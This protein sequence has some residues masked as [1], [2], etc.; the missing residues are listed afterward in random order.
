M[1]S[2]LESLYHRK[3][4]RVFTKDEV[5][6]DVKKQLIEA[7]MQAPSAGNM[8]LYSIIDIQDESIKRL[9]A[10]SCDHQAFIAEAPLVFI[11]CAD[12]HRAWQGMRYF[13]DKDA[14]KPDVGDMFLAMSDALICAQNMVVA[15]ESFGLGSCYI[16][17]ILENYEYHRELL[18]LPD[19]VWPIC[20]LVIGYPTTQ[21]KERPK[22]KRFNPE[23]VMHTN[24]YH[25]FDSFKHQKHILSYFLNHP[26][27]L[28]EKDYY[29]DL[30]KRKYT[31]DFT[32]EMNRSVKI[33]LDSLK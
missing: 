19:A 33:M 28:N 31:S 27:G 16:G 17:D 12:Y 11:F 25:S 1:N 13:I 20:M 22:P 24:S 21:Q 14:R 6:L 4:T 18:K 32:D 26:K 9:L 7:A 8:H 15:A 29:S 5:T 23:F 3:S 10:D 30:Y 2:I